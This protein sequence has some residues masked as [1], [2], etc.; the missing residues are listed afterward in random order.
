MDTIIKYN[1]VLS[2]YVRD[3]CVVIPYYDEAELMLS[4]ME[5]NDLNDA[6]QDLPLCPMF[7]DYEEEEI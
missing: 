4:I 3:E 6:D 2:L 7:L 1:L 5:E